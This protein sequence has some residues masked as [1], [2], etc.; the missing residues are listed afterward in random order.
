MTL[1]L[2]TKFAAVLT[3]LALLALGLLVY[4][5]FRRRRRDWRCPRCNYD[6]NGLPHRTIGPYRY[7]RTTVT[8]FLS[9]DPAS[10]WLAIQVYQH[11]GRTWIAVIAR[12]TP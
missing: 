6:M 8:R 12:Q 1:E 9:D 2:L 10:R 7:R 5:V 11:R 4:E 3:S